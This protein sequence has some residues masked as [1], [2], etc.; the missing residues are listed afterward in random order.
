MC[1]IFGILNFRCQLENVN[2][3][4]AGICKNY[5]YSFECECEPGARHVDD[6]LTSSCYIENCSGDDC[7]NGECIIDEKEEMFTCVC[8]QGYQS[9]NGTQCVDINECERDSTCGDPNSG[10]C[11]NQ[12]GSFLCS[13]N[14]G[15]TNKNGTN[16]ECIVYMLVMI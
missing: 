2:C 14:D 13:C 16:S 5:F 6:T 15:F 11:F 3:G 12:A 7:G 4:K 9:I 8:N 1:L 10:S